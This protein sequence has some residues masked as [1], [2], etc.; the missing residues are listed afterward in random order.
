MSLLAY[1]I[2]SSNLSM[3]STP[4][5]LNVRPGLDS[6]RNP[7][8]EPVRTTGQMHGR[9]LALGQPVLTCRLRASDQSTS[10]IHIIEAHAA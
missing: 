3:A 10:L 1:L 9:G 6:R 7:G 8:A 5:S 2:M 4:C